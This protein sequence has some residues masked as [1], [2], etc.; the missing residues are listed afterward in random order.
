MSDVTYTTY[1]TVGK[2][3][4]V[5]DLITS[6]TPTETPFLSSISKE[7]IDATNPQWQEDSL[8]APA[9]NKNVQ[10]FDAVATARTPTVMRQTYTQI[11][12]DTFKISKTD[13]RVKK[14]GRDKEVAYQSMKMGKELKK[15]LEFALVGA[16]QNA[17]V[18]NGTDTPSAMA[19]AF[20]QAVG[21]AAMIHSDLIESNGGTARAFT[22]ALLLSVHQ[23]AYNAGA[24]PKLLMINPSDSLKIAEFTGAS[25]RNRTINDGSKKVVNAVDIYVSPFGELKVVLNRVMKKFVADPA[26]VGEA[27]VYNP[28]FW[29]LLVLRDWK[30]EEL[31]KTG[32]N[33]KHMMVGE[34]SLKHRNFKATGRITDLNGS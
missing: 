11:L 18:G 23:K 26:S 12:A 5:S 30:R 27:L 8:R 16:A 19:S 17:A 7:G 4:D 25:G 24:E 1:D 15:D 21:G 13:D 20:G 9:A 31:A 34:F 14:Y 28:D 32:D 3:E 10:G 22:E 29:K 2:A 33:E 6:I